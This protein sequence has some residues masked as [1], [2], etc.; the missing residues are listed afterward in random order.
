MKRRD[1]IT[2]LGGSGGVA[3]RGKRAAARAAGSNGPQEKERGLCGSQGR[4]IIVLK[5]RSSDAFDHAAQVGLNK[6]R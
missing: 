3:A 5:I 1:F 2:V 4:V 6:A